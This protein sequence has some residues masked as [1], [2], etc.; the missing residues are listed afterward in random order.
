MEALG[1][2]NQK[3]KEVLKNIDETQHT[4]KATEKYTVRLKENLAENQ[5]RLKRV[6]DEILTLRKEGK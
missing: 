4:L 5:A 1:L 2:L 6:N 3:R